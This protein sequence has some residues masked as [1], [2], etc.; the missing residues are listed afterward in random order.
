MACTN[1]QTGRFS[2]KTE[3]RTVVIIRPTRLRHMKS[4]RRNPQR[5]AS[6][7]ILHCTLFLCVEGPHCCQLNST[8]RSGSSSC[9]N[10]CAIVHLQISGVLSKANKHVVVV[11]V[12]SRTLDEFQTKR[13]SFSLTVFESASVFISTALTNR[14]CKCVGSLRPRQTF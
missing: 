1:V 12:C 4:R 14:D 10:S 13:I 2:K 6:E 5:S 9:C 3:R 7:Q 8:A 11:T